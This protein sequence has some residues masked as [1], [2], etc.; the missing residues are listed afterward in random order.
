M[1]LD[2]ASSFICF[3]NLSVY[4]VYIPYI[5]ISSSSVLLYIFSSRSRWGCQVT[6]NGLYKISLAKCVNKLTSISLWGV[7]GITDSGVV[8]LVNDLIISNTS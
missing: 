4:D 7:T 6:D 2:I 1:K 8:Q 3:H 5:L